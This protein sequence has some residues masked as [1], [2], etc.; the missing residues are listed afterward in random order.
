MSPVAISRVIDGRHCWHR[1]RSRRPVASN[2]D[3]PAAAASSTTTSLRPAAAASTSAEREPP[4]LVPAR[5]LLRHCVRIAL[6]PA[7]GRGGRGNGGGRTDI[8]HHSDTL[9]TIPALRQQSACLAGLLRPPGLGGLW[10]LWGWGG[11][12]QQHARPAALVAAELRRLGHLLLAAHEQMLLLERHR[13]RWRHDDSRPPAGGAR[14]RLAGEGAAGSGCAVAGR[15]GGVLCGWV[16]SRRV[17]R[18]LHPQFLRPVPGRPPGLLPLAPAIRSSA[19]ERLLCSTTTGGGGCAAPAP[20]QAAAARPAPQNGS[21]AT[22]PVRRS[23]GM[24]APFTAKSS[25]RPPGA[26][27]RASVAR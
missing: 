1:R 5:A 10:G 22:S 26:S 27:T 17:P 7:E 21:G 4:Q 24:S 6:G 2:T 15:G 9:C 8:H 16:R 13:L 11:G 14:V 19:A 20:H 23:L 3:C 12:F 18:L 25:A